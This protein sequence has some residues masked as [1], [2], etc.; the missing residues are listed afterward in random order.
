MDLKI[1][2]KK[3]AHSCV[4][5]AT[6]LPNTKLGSHIELQLIR[7]ATSVAANYRAAC[8]AQTKKGFISKLSI[9]IEEADESIFWIEFLKEENLKNGTQVND[10]LKEAKE[11]T[12]IFISSRITAS[13][14]I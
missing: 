11:L 5:L 10:V 14:N 4:K 3:F 9:V 12:A 7:S 8:L 6:E 13:K 1:R 2:S